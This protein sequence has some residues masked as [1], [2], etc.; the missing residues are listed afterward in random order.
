ME[1][2][3]RPKVDLYDIENYNFCDKNPHK[4]MRDISTGAR[5]TRLKRK[6]EERGCV[7]SVEAVLLVHIHH[8]PHIFVVRDAA[9]QYRLPGGKCHE[10]EDDKQCIMRKLRTFLGQEGGAAMGSH[11]GFTVGDLLGEW[12][13]PNLEALLYPYCPP[14]IT[15]PKEVRRVYLVRMPATFTFS[16]PK[17]MKLL[18]V[19]LFELFDNTTRFGSVVLASLPQCLSRF[20][21]NY[22]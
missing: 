11:L 17:N 21:I 22:C 8:H 5:L 20:Q 3:H 1:L 9:G 6:F 16:V 4:P 18:S 2:A 13:R 14:H 7:R 12:T 15:R 10:V 19:P